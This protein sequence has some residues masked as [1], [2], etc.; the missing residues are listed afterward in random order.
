MRGTAR[1]SLVLLLACTVLGAPRPAF[2]A[3][4]SLEVLHPFTAAGGQ[5][6]GNLVRDS[7]GV[8]YGTTRRDGISLGSVYSLTPDGS[9]GFIH[10][11]LHVFTVGEGFYPE[12]GLTLAS[13]GLLYGTTSGG[14]ESAGIV[15]RISTDGQNFSILHTFWS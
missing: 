1:S 8:L 7:N 13:D 4:R 12:A 10:K 3:S 11:T 15:F 9:G 5:P 14:Q 6:M 2:A